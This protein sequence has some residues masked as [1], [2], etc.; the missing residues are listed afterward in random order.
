MTDHPSAS[1]LK[2]HTLGR[3]ARAWA[4]LWRLLDAIPLEDWDRPLGDG[5]PVKV[6]VAHLAA[7]EHSLLAL[8]DGRDRA[9]ALAVPAD[10]WASH[11][12]DAINRAIATAAASLTPAQA[13]AALGDSHQALLARLNDLTD[14]DFRRPY[15]HFQADH[16]PPDD[17]GYQAPVLVWILGN[18]SQ[19]YDEHLDWL[20]PGLA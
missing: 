15:A 8:L 14:D 16:V 3:I 20:R 4:D 17:P 7:W 1:G 9:E 12:V 10:L 6:H 5:W 11:D 19:H 13:R 2:A 18:T